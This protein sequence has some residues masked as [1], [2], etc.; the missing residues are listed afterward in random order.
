MRNRYEVICKSDGSLVGYIHGKDLKQVRLF[1]KYVT[2]PNFYP[3]VQDVTFR[4][5]GKTKC[6]WIFERI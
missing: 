4:F 5:L 6:N 3:R 2:D 1:Y